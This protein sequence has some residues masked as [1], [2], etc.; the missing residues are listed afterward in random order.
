[1]PRLIPKTCPPPKAT[2]DPGQMRRVLGAAVMVNVCKRLRSTAFFNFFYRFLISR[3]L[4]CG[5]V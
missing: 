5:G 3:T 4:A 2:I 1:M